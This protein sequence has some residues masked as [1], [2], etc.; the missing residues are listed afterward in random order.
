MA[1]QEIHLELLL[2][3]QVLDSTGKAI[4][5]IEEVRA[6]PQGE[7][8]VVQEYLIGYAAILERLSAWTIGLGI[9]HLLGARKIHGGYTVPWEKLDL[10]NPDQP[11][12]RCSLAELK[13]VAETE[14]R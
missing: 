9:L 11:R 5:R 8:W 1:D 6:E 7:D 2:G 10:T 14:T 3:K 13:A 4:G 12:L